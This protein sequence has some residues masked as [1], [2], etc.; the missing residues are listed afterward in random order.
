MAQLS[1]MRKS[2]PLL[3]GLKLMYRGKVRDTYEIDQEK[4]LVVS[5]DGLSIFDFV[6]NALVPEKGMILT[7]MSHFWFKFLRGALRT[8]FIAAG[9]KI[10]DYLPAEL[11]GNTDLQ[12]RAMVVRRLQMYPVEF[13]A[14]GYLTGSGLAEYKRSGTV[15]GH[16]LPPVG[17]Q[18][19][20]KLPQILDTPTTKAEEGHDE[21]LDAAAIRAMY[22]YETKALLDVFK[23]VASFAEKR[24][25][26]FADTKLEFG[27]D[28]GGQVA[29]G[30]EVATP[31]SS[32]WWNHLTWLEG[33]KAEERRAPPPLDKQLVRAWGI[34][35]GVNKF[36]PRSPEHVAQVHALMVPEHLIRATTQTYR[37]IFWRL[38]ARTVEN[39]FGCELGVSLPRKKKRVSIVFGSES[40]IKS[41]PI[42]LHLLDDKYSL[43]DGFLEKPSVHVVSC[44]RNPVELDSFASSGCGGADVVIVAGG[45]AFAL[46]GV[47][48]ALLESKGWNIP[49]IGVALG[50][51]GTRAFEAA[52]FSIEELPDQPVVM[53]EI[54]GGVYAGE[55]G[56]ISAL[57]RISFGELP[58]PKPRTKKPAK[59]NIDF[60]LK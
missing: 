7:A 40:D 6:L 52:K 5:T 26:L 31:D 59:F 50:Q 10:D 53:D 8:H 42:A 32:R 27:F 23:L 60:A 55:E 34:E 38:F 13:I 35:Q 28:G 19:G 46:P 51:A 54:N 43:Q 33:R 48:D 39:Y 22:P 20:D 2:V 3:E 37:Y 9:R 44:H 1:P 16:K 36:D 21:A 57:E 15:C 58:P 12:S 56:L 4:A 45:K 29:L 25:I 41:M 47:L 30:D 14:R 17:L 24:G 18:D 11:C 49:V